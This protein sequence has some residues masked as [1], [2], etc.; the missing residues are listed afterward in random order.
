MWLFYVTLLLYDDSYPVAA[1]N[2]VPKGYGLGLSPRFLCMV[3]SRWITHQVICSDRPYSGVCDIDRHDIDLYE[4]VRSQ[5]WRLRR[6]KHS[7]HL[8][9]N[10]PT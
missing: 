4:A 2:G 9:Q 7:P 8:Y 3:L 1:F 6:I 10:I 5:F